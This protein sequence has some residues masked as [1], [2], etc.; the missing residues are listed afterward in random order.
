MNPLPDDEQRLQAL[1]ARPSP[2]LADDGFSLRVLSAL[3]AKSSA[4]TLAVLPIRSILCTTAA[5]AGLA[6]A[7]QQGVSDETLEFAATQL[8]DAF[9][10]TSPRFAEPAI[11]GALAVAGLSLLYAFKPQ[12]HR[13]L[14]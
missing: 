4:S 8:R 10:P 9:S 2:P 6:L 13:L 1:L 5:L 14:K 7:W 3:P 12:P 11:V